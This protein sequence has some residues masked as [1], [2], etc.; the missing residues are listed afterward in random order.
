ME[1]LSKEIKELKEK[2]LFFEQLA[3]MGKLILCSTHELNNLLE[4]IRVS[5]SKVQGKEI[6][7]SAK[8]CYFTEALEGLH[9]M[10]L[11]IK[12]LLSLNNP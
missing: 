4:E 3:I 10:S 9:K 12:S 11:T 6:D 8:E 7:S 1:G 2:L 5:L